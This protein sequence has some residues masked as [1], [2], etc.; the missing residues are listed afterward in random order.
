MQWALLTQVKYLPSADIFEMLDVP[1]L[2]TYRAQINQDIARLALEIIIS[3]SIFNM[4]TTR[5]VMG[6]LGRPPP[7]GKISTL[8]LKHEALHPIL[9]LAR[10]SM[11]N[12]LAVK[13]T[14]A[15]GD[16]G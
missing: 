15:T 2:D 5:T 7:V 10:Q 11:A 3:E 8:I 13:L 14:A 1:T 16:D 4:N 6:F 9:Q 12:F